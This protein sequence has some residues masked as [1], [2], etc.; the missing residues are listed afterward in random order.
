V[1]VEVKL[2]D[3]DLNI[4]RPEMSAK[5]AFLTGEAAPQTAPIVT[6]SKK[7]IV[8]NAS[9]KAVWVIRGGDAYRVAVITGREL[10]DGIEIRSGLEGGEEVILDPP[11]NLEDGARVTTVTS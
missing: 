2:R 7:A 11:A 8:A 1:K 9:G 6:I 4:I 10:Q 5:V 3:P